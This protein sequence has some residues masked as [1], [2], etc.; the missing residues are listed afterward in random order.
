MIQNCSSGEDE[1]GCPKPEPV[2]CRSD[3]FKCSD[4]QCISKSRVCDGRLDCSN[5]EEKCDKSSQE[6]TIKLGY[7][8]TCAPDDFICLDRLR[9]IRPDQ[10]CALSPLAVN[11]G[12]FHIAFRIW[13]EYSQN[14]Y[15]TN[16]RTYRFRCNSNIDCADGSDEKDCEHQTKQS[17]QCNQNQFQCSDEKCIDSARLCDGTKVRKTRINNRKISF[18]QLRSI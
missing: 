15:R 17:M 13:S 12:N 7:N 4:N 11:F 10:R 2:T 16:I 8:I 5:D 1:K 9:C 18:S 14:F 6:E 3:Q